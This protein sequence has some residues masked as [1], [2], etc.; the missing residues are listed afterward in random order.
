M[1]QVLNQALHYSE[2]SAQP[3]LSDFLK[4]SDSQHC[5]LFSLALC[6]T[7]AYSHFYYGQGGFNK[8][9]SLPFYN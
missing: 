2:Q 8:S 3:Y 9:G 5:E 1:S 7:L 6:G 4:C